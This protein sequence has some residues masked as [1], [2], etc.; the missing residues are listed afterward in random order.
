[1][2]ENRII[3]TLYDPCCHAGFAHAVVDSK[4]YLFFTTPSGPAETPYFWDGGIDGMW[5]RREG[6]ALFISADNGNTYHLARQITGEGEL[7]AYSALCATRNGSLLCAWE[8]GPE[9][10]LY[11]DIKYTTFDIAELIKSCK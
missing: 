5:G 9:E 7:A 4:E 3:D 11:Q 8:S 2:V 1:M 6:L 10:Q